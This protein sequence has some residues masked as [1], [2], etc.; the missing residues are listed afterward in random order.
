MKSTV[1]SVVISQKLEMKMLAV[2]LCVNE[3]K[4][5]RSINYHHNH[6]TSITCQRNQ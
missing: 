3:S 2:G 5:P 4:I 1:N 6:K